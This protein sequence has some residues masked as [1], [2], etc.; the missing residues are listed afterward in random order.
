MRDKNKATFCSCINLFINL[1]YFS[2][3]A[4]TSNI[5][6]DSSAIISSGDTVN[7]LA[8]TTRCAC[9]PEI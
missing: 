6:V 9:P 3:C 2:A 5:D 7:A 4:E 8:I 1:Y